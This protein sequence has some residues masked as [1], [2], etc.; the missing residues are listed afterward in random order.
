M[1]SCNEFGSLPRRSPRE[2]EKKKN[3]VRITAEAWVKGYKDP[4]EDGQQEASWK[5][6]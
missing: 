5:L 2:E 3:L 1:V 4:V 6:S